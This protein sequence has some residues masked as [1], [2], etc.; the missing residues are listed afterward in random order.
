MAAPEDNRNLISNL[1]ARSLMAMG[2]TGQ[3]RDAVL[4]EMI[5]CI[6]E[7]AGRAED[8]ARLLRALQEREE[9]HSTGIGDGVALP[10]TR[11]ALSGLVAQPVIVFG[12]HSEGVAYGAIDNKPVRL[13]FLIV[14]TSVTQHLQVL[15]RISRLLRDVRL[16]QQLLVSATSDAVLAAIRQAEVSQ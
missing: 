7:I 8:R 12:R 15:A 10:H 16:R 14:T 2:L 1:M 5:G 13:F 11:N 4:E 3:S 6:P 9:L